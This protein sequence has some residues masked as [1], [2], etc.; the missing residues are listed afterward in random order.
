MYTAPDWTRSDPLYR[1]TNHQQMIFTQDQKFYFRG[2][3]FESTIAIMNVASINT[4]LRPQIDF[5]VRE[6]DIDT[7]TMSDL[8]L[9]E[10]EF[11]TMHAGERV[12]RSVTIITPFVMDYRVVAEY[13]RVYPVIGK[14][15]MINDEPFET[16]P[17]LIAW[18]IRQVDYL[19]KITNPIDNIV[20]PTLQN[21][22]GLEIDL[23][24][25]RPNNF[26]MDEEWAVDV[27]GGIHVI[28][29]LG[30]S[31]YAGVYPNNSTRFK[32]INM[33]TNEELVENNDYKLFGQDLQKTKMTSH[34]PGVFNYIGF[35][36]PFVGRV[37][38]TYHAF[39]GDPTL[40]D[41]RVIMDNLTNVYAFVAAS[42][43]VTYDNLKG[44][45]IIANIWSKL[46]IMEDR[47][48]M[49]LNGL[50]TGADV[51]N[52]ATLRKRITANSTD[53]HWWSIAYLYKMAGSD[54]IVI[55]DTLKIRLK[56]KYTGF[57]FD[58]VV[59]VNID[60]PVN[61]MDV[62]TLSAI[63]PKGYIPFENYDEIG[64]I[65]RPQF[66]IIYN[67]NEVEHS[68]VILQIGLRLKTV[69]EDIIGVENW[70][71]NQSCWKLVP[72]VND[73][74]SP[75]DFVV[76][77]PA[78]GHFWDTNNQDSRLES[79][80]I[81]FRDGTLVWAGSKALN[82]ANRTEF[83]ELN[84]FLENDTDITR[85]R[86]IRFELAE[87]GDSRYAVEAP[88]I[89]G[90]ELLKATANFNYNGKNAFIN[91]TMTRNSSGNVQ[92]NVDTFVE[93]GV[94]SNPLY[95]RHVILFTDR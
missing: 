72:T 94:S 24:L 80:L 68:G 44:A 25:E 17:D 34:K 3:V 52:G 42:Q 14:V 15:A 30:G 92:I 39:G 19:T 38:V 78:V 28:H 64:N 16:N 79:M 43:F 86:K 48:L 51:N 73:A 8:K 57:M 55:A 93:A 46:R 81:P 33:A 11:F 70:S 87:D 58:A 2:P 61:K 12:V 29:P 76:E 69:Q 67:V 20:S 40:E 54:E 77:L 18:L 74:V 7:R 90:K 75:E 22:L 36:K 71:G 85:F 82:D 35:L 53:L 59:A 62:T 21:P 84:H 88:F 26:I 32:L 23:H 56:T 83:F 5:E 27:P 4:E 60:S 41:I 6:E 65:I 31:F 47:M 63:F 45:P 10:P 37:Q 89:P 13:Q 50:P 95:L 9:K 66:R 49:L 91:G 1:V